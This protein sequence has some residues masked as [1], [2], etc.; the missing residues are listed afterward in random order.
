MFTIGF[1]FLFTVGGVSGVILSNAG[2][3]LLFHDTMYVVA[4][5]HYVLSM[6]AVFAIFAGF[7]YW[8][9]KIVGLQYDEFLAKV[10]FFLFFI[11]VNITFLPLHFLGIA[12]MPR[13][14]IDYPDFYRGWNLVSTVGSTISVIAT[15]VFFYIVCS[16]FVYGE[17]GRKYPYV[18]KVLTEVQLTTLFLMKNNLLLK[19]KISSLSITFV[20]FTLFADA[21]RE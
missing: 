21:P 14:I 13:R 20:W 10:H 1:I 17:F 11:G 19:K 12:G 15:V 7:Y 2:L 8:I 18:L 6:G 9:E 3:D 16:M 4:H 5:F